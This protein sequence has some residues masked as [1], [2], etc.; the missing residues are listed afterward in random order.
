MSANEAEHDLSALWYH[1][2][3][4]RHIMVGLLQK[5]FYCNN[6]RFLFIRQ[7]NISPNSEELP[8][9]MYRTCVHV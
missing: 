8:D 9:F 1:D 3:E 7:C 5:Q 2:G 6:G 4:H